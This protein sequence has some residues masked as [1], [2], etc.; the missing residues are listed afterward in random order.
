MGKEKT[1]KDY[2]GK[3]KKR[4]VSDEMEESYLSYAMSVIVAR[5]LP[6]VRDGLKPVHRKIL[7][8]MWKLGLKHNAKFRKSAAVVGEV[9]GKYHPHGD[10]ATYGSMVRMAQD[11]SLRAPLVE[12]Q[13]NFGSMDGDQ[14]A[15]MRYTEARLSAI[16]EEMLFD[17]DKDTVDFVDNYDATRKMPAYLPAKLPQLLLNGTVGIAVGMAT[18]IPPHNLEEIIDGTIA[19]IENQDITTEELM[20]FVKGPDFPTGG[21]AYNQKDITEAYS[22]GRGGVVTRA[23][24]DIVEGKKGQ[25]QIVITEVTYQTNKSNLIKKIADLVRD[26]KIAGIKNVNDESDKDGVR[27]V[28]ELKKDAFPKKILNQLF[29]MTELQKTFHFNMLALVNGIEPRVLNLKSII[30][31]YVKHRQNVVIRRTEFELR[32]AKARAHILEGL[33][34][35]LDHID[36]IIALIKKSKTKEEAHGNLIKKFK[37]SDLQATAILEMKLQTLAGLERKKIEDELKEMLALIKKLEGILGSPKKILNIIKKEILAIREKFGTP[38]K[39]SVLKSSVDDFSQEDLVANEETIVSLTG[40]GYVKRLAPNSFRSQKRGGKGV[41]GGKVKDG[42]SLDK[43]LGV[44]THDNLFFFTNSGKVF[45]IKAYELP[46]SSRTAKGQAIVNFL[47]IAP[48]EK[49]TSILAISK[50]SKAEFMIMQTVRGKIKK[51]AL[52]DFENVR[53]SGLI[54]IKLQKGDSLEWVK[55]TSGKD[56]VMIATANGQAIHFKESQVRSMGRAASGVRAIRLKGDDQVMGM[57]II[58]KAQEK[59]ELL[60]VTEKGYGKK[61]LVSKYKIQSRG[62]SGIKT[63]NLTEKTGKL[64]SVRIIKKNEEL[65]LLASSDK[66][67]IIRT[68]VKSISVLGR[69]TQGVRIMNLKKE[70]KIAAVTLI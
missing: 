7:Y 28:V 10:T 39:T 45:S 23:K 1:E 20:K 21:V 70:E 69:S 54:A 51:T 58:R 65:D 68:P 66:G 26:G 3:I 63:A 8:A 12:G 57:E 48:D 30:G 52:T 56:E 47:Q 31:Q 19:Y 46:L 42:D 38:R 22:T 33:K 24:A 4:P 62:G 41:A 61:T 64:V 5:A 2:I 11:F 37:F 60:V 44:M 40:D 15:A 67:Q 53:R 32:K 17:I 59:P 16:S 55:M 36:E 27:I 6:D 18:N 29:K 25:F 9:L 13:G 34:K 50:S 43:V 49:I 14:A 35:A